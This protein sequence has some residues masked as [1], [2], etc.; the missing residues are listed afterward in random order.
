VRRRHG[1]L[2]RDGDYRPQYT[3]DPSRTQAAQRKTLDWVREVSAAAPAK[4]LLNCMNQD[5]VRGAATS[6]SSR[7]CARRPGA[8][9]RIGWRR[10]WST[11]DVFEVAHVDA[12]RGKRIS[13]GG[14]RDRRA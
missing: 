11:S 5:G 14:D 7:P 4:S 2:E 3:G 9:D 1:S 6:C 10:R 12:R 13:Y 8:S